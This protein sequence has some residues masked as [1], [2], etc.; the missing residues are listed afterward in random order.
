[1]NSTLRMRLNIPVMW[2]DCGLGDQMFSHGRSR[3]FLY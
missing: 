3:N 2:T 1:M